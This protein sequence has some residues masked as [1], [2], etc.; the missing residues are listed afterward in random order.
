MAIFGYLH[1]KFREQVEAINNVGPFGGEILVEYSVFLSD[2]FGTNPSVAS[3]RISAKFFDSPSIPNQIDGF[4]NDDSYR[5]S[6][7]FVQ[8]NQLRN[9]SLSDVSL[10]LASHL[11]ENSLARQLQS[12]RD[13]P[14][15]IR[16]LKRVKP[17]DI[18]PET[19]GT[20]LNRPWVNII[21]PN[22]K[23]F[24]EQVTE[25]REEKVQ[26]LD[27]FGE[28]VA[29]FFGARP[30]VYTYQGTLLNSINHDWKN[31][32]Q[33]NYEHF[34]RGSQAV[35]NRATM[36][37]Q[38]DDVVVEGYML[39]SQIRQTGIDDATV[40]FTFNL[41]VLN[42]SAINPRNILVARQRRSDLTAFEHALLTSLTESLTLTESQSTEDMQTFLLMREWLNSNRFPFAGNAIHFENTN[43]LESE[44][45]NP[46]EGN[47]APARPANEAFGSIHTGTSADTG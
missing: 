35:K 23:F 21:P 9:L 12:K 19:G 13:Q 38:Y 4:S 27:T 32:F 1:T 36:F 26:V 22:T 15:I 30:E 28:F 5:Q 31:E 29:F 10:G 45:P 46:S 37:L 18:N 34:L 42:R 3:D 2:K 14:A 39:N 11:R 33:Q 20:E 7:H 24:L 6:K 44:R 41:L 40:P 16:L 8:N 47:D 25:N 43:K 17:G